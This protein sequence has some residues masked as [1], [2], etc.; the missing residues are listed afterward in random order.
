MARRIAVVGGGVAGLMAAWWASNYGYDVVVYEADLSSLTATRV[1]AGIIDPTIDISLA[2]VALETLSLLKRLGLGLESRLLWLHERGS[3]RRL[4]RLL[5]DKGI[6]E[7]SVAG[8]ESI[9]LGRYT[10]NLGYGEELHVINTIIV[11]TGEF[12]SLASSASNVD[13]V[14]DSV[15]YVGCGSVGLKRGG[16]REFDAIIVAAGPW[17]G[18][19][20][21]LQALSNMLRVY[22]CE[23]LIIRA[24][25]GPFAVVDDILD[26]YLSIHASGD[27]VLGNG[28][29][30][31]IASPLDG[32]RY[33]GDVLD[34][35]ISR[36]IERLEGL[37]EAELITPV[38]A[39]C[40]VGRD[41]RPVLG[42][43]PGCSRVYL[44]AG[45]D[46]VGVTLAPVLARLVVESIATGSQEP[47]PPEMAASRPTSSSES[48]VKE[49]VEEC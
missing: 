17:T 11:D 8:E 15:E 6:I 7:R 19:I 10:V 32:Y 41:A 38:S 13:I 3:C 40:V 31:E 39:P 9:R 43:L 23:A 42:M 48:V 28:C 33:S 21:G 44:L 16:S 46:G 45:L 25:G 14:E 29:C 5:S 22:R 12:Y 24:G 2:P 20:S 1:S 47:I 36:S 27:G 30:V 49:P 34:A 4:E 35:V 18:F 26:F 37:G